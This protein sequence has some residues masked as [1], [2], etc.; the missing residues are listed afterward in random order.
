MALVLIRH[1]LLSSL[2]WLVISLPDSQ[3]LEVEPRDN[4]TLSC[5]NVS[6]SPTVALWMRGDNT[7]KP[8]IISSVFGT[9]SSSVRYMDGF[10]QGRHVLEYNLFFINLTILQVEVSDSGWYFCLFYHKTKLVVVNST[11]L[12]I[13]GND[14]FHEED[15]TNYK[16]DEQLIMV[17]GI[18][19]A[20]I[21]MI[22][23]VV[24]VIFA[25]LVISLPDSKTVEVEQMGDVTLSCTNVSSYPTAAFWMRG[26]NTSK[27][28]MIS[29][30][31]GSDS[32]TVRYMDGFQQG[33]HVLDSNLIFI[34]LTILQV[35]VSDSGWYCC[36]FYHEMKL[37]MDPDGI[38]YSSL[39]FPQ[40]KNRRGRPKSK[41][42]PEAN[43]VYAATR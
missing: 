22:V 37:V 28:I 24:L 14:A 26:D 32:N 20:M 7:S 12:K 11:F 18:L 40:K 42:N 25:W 10:Q 21:A 23:L 1:L 43:V 19:V 34:N 2:T 13:N 15:D 27:P 4:V 36:L 30:V 9:D 31:F 8:I 33:R 6:T 3:T 41:N 38:T 35:E 29:S 16:S 17:G 39:S 5:T